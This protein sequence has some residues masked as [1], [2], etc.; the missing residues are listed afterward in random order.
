M[1]MA[2]ISKSRASEGS[3]ALSPALLHTALQV[4]YAEQTRNLLESQPLHEM[5][6]TVLTKFCEARDSSFVSNVEKLLNI[7]V[8]EMCECE[9]TRRHSLHYLHRRHHLHHLRRHHLHL[10]SHLP[11]SHHL[12]CGEMLEPMTYKNFATAVSVAQIVGNAP[13]AGQPSS[14]VTQL[15]QAAGPACPS[16]ACGSR[17]SIVRYLM[18][19]VP[20]WMCVALQYP[21]R[22]GPPESADISTLLQRVDLEVDLQRAFRGVLTPL[23]MSLRGVLCSAATRCSAYF[24]S[25]EGATQ[26]SWVCFD[27]DAVTTVGDEFGAVVSRC[28]FALSQP[29]LLFYEVN[30]TG[31]ATECV[32]CA[33]VDAPSAPPADGGGTPPPAASSAAMQC[34][35]RDGPN[36]APRPASARRSPLTAA[37]SSAPAASGRTREGAGIPL[38]APALPPQ[39]QL[40]VSPIPRLVPR[41]RTYPPDAPFALRRRR[42]LSRSLLPAPPFN[43]KSEC[44]RNPTSPCPLDLPL[45]VG[46]AAARLRAAAAPTPPCPPSPSPLG[47]TYDLKWG[48]ISSSTPSSTRSRSLPLRDSARPTPEPPPPLSAAGNRAAA[49]CA[50]SRDYTGY[51]LR[52]FGAS[53]ERPCLAPNKVVST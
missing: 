43:D 19:P 20:G 37:P 26:G 4:L 2:E 16:A 52:A 27:D 44:N 5:F 18:P 34:A 50:N 33:V 15:G 42:R 35:A 36:P 9:V 10:H 49:S 8:L 25:K 17:M 28:A 32:S 22:S 40:L 23:K 13:A 45:P 11:S 41:S 38:L 29:A 39:P 6:E 12:Q 14:L 31:G 1:L 30:D 47:T 21:P 51:C 24:L 46:A 3:P 53:R 48:D 7:G